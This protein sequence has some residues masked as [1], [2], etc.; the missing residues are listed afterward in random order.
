MD[1]GNEFKISIAQDVFA[2]GHPKKVYGALVMGLLA[3]Y[4]KSTSGTQKIKTYSRFN[5][6]TDPN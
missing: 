5:T 3:K 2:I 4:T 6:V 1:L